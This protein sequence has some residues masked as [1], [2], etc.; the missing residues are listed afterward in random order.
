MTIEFCATN[1]AVAETLDSGWQ[2]GATA[3]D[4]RPLIAALTDKIDNSG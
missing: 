4:G 3:G 2:N 1:A